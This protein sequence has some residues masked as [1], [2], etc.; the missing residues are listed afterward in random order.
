MYNFSAEI[1]TLQLKLTMKIKREYE[2]H[3]INVSTFCALR[4]IG[5]II[6]F[7]FSVKQPI[8]VSV[9]IPIAT[10]EITQNEIF[11]FVLNETIVK[12]MINQGIYQIKL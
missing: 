3:Q 6:L 9:I 8:V 4:F 7:L 12:L 11:C 10:G 5:D 2:I 1:R